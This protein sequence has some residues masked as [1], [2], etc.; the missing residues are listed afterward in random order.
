[1]LVLSDGPEPLTGLARGEDGSE[2][3]VDSLLPS[4]QA[5]WRAL[6]TGSRVWRATARDPGP[7]GFWSRALVVADAPSSHFDRL[8]EGLAGGLELPG[9]TACLAL[10]GQGFHGQRG[11]PWLSA[12]GNLHLCA[13][14][15]EPGLAAR[16][17]PSL[18]MLP[19]VALVDA[20]RAMTGGA[21]RPGIKWVNDV[22]VGGRKIGGVLTATQTQGDRVSAVLLGIGLNVATAPPVPPTPFV[23]SVGCLAESGSGVTLAD[24]VAG[25]LAALGRRMVEV[26]TDGGG[27]LLDAY[28]DASLVIG[29]D[30]R[31]FADPERGESPSTPVARG[32]VYGI[33]ADLSLILEGVDTPVASGRLAFAE[34]CPGLGP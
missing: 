2:V 8:R 24:A 10:A 18:P 23:P 13:A 6:G 4:D 9:P 7:P 27:A 22:L 31:V 17:A 33:A 21:L 25:V 26:V 28:R 19:A 16:D 29:R 5:L 12:P 11:R 3:R 20:V 15:P 32:K 34:D 1:M 14:F 30:V